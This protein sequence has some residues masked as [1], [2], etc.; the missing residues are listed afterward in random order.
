MIVSFLLGDIKIGNLTHVLYIIY[1]GFI[2]Y[3]YLEIWVFIFIYGEINI[4]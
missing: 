1:V 4:L 3:L 2:D